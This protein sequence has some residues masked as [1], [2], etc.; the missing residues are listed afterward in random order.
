MLRSSLSAN[1]VPLSSAR[2]FFRLKKSSLSIK[3]TCMRAA[4]MDAT[5]MI[6]G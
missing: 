4:C 1:S 5:F 3:Y 2:V 6:R